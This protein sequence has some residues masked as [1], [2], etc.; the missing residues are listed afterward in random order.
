MIIHNGKQY[1]RVSDILKPFCDFSNIDEAVLNNKAR[2]GTDVHK[3]INDDICEEF[4]IIFPESHGYLSSY[5][6][7]KE[8]LLPSFSLAE[9]RLYCDEK[10]ISGQIDTLVQFKGENG[11]VLVDF[12]T[13]AQESPIVWPMQAHLYHYL[14]IKNGWNVTSRFLFVKLDKHGKLPTVFQYC[15]DPNLRAK[16]MDAIDLHFKIRKD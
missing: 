9:T 15:F 3:A 14:L 16:C 12:K 6:Q 7:W 5:Y 8:R 13:S 4:P 1:A 10:M 11:L 2:I